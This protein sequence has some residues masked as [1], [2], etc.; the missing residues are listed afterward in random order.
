[1]GEG[2]AGMLQTATA[3]L[4]LDWS[5]LVLG[6]LLL[7]ASPAAE[8]FAGQAGAVSTL[9]AGYLT[10]AVCFIFAGLGTQSFVVALLAGSLLG[11]SAGVYVLYQL[12]PESKPPLSDWP[13]DHCV[14]KLIYGGSRDSSH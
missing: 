10:L 7:A 11:W 5:F 8:R 6:A 14:P 12:R 2:E 1:V 4:T 13:A 9:L 3:T